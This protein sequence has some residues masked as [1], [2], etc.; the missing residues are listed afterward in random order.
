MA[1]REKE[2]RRMERTMGSRGI[3]GL[4]G[5]IILIAFIVTAAASGITLRPEDAMEAVFDAL[6]LSAIPKCM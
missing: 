3:V 5:A 6:R 2:L 1:V 4:E